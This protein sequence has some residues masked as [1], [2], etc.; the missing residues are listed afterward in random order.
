MYLDKQTGII[1]AVGIL[2]AFIIGILIG[3]FAITK[4]SSKNAND[5]RFENKQ[6]VADVLD[7]VDSQSL[8]SFLQILTKE[9]H[10]AASD[11]DRYNAM[12]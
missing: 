12:L 8:R 11:R 6:F 3:N 9:P 10:I 1:C 7:K 4:S 5:D 2:S